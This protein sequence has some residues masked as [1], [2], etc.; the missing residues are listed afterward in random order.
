MPPLTLP[1]TVR[2]SSGDTHLMIRAPGPI[3]FGAIGPEV[4][5]AADLP[6]ETHLHH[7]LGR[8][9]PSAVLGRPPLLSGLTLT[10]TAQTSLLVDG[11]VVLGCVAGP[12]AGRSVALDGEPVEVGRDADADLQLNDPELSRRHLR[13]DC[14]ENG[15]QVTDLGSA[16]G[17]QVDGVAASGDPTRPGGDESTT[18]QDVPDG[19]VIRAGSS[20]LR[21]L[22][23]GER[24]LSR[25][26]DGRGHLRVARP[27]RVLAPFHVDV[28]ADPGPAPERPR[29]PLPLLAAGIGAVVGGVIAWVTGMWMFLLFAALGPVYL[30]AGAL[31]DRV[32][33]RRSHRQAV[34]EHRRSVQERERAVAAAVLADRRDAW[35]RHS[36][37]V[38]LARRCRSGS[39]RL[40]ERRPTEPEFAQLVLAV[41]RRPARLPLTDPPVADDMPLPV[42]LADIGVLGLT[43]HAR[44]T[45]RS[46]LG[47][48]VALHSPVDLGLVVFSAAPDLLPLRDLPHAAD[49]PLGAR[50]LV[51]GPAEVGPAL[52]M[53]HSALAGADRPALTVLVLDGAGAWRD[54]PGMAQLLAAAGDPRLSGLAVLC[55]EEERELLPAECQAVAD[56]STTGVAVRG[57]QVCDGGP[58]GV[59]AAYLAG[60][61]ADLAPLR[62]IDAALGALP[63]RCILGDWVRLGRE[64]DDLRRRWADPS[65][66]TV[67]GVGRAGPVEIDLDRDGPHL[68]VAGTTGAGKSELLQTLVVGLAAAAPPSVTS[69]LLVDY[70][71]GAAFA[72]LLGLPHAAGLITDLDADLAARALTSLRAEI[73]SRESALARAGHP[74]LARWRAADPGA[75]GRLVIVVDEFATLAADLPDFLAGLL[76]ISRR[77]R[78]LGLHLVLAT[79]RPAG[80]VT[81]ALRA[82]IG[83]RI[84][85]RVT[86]DAESRDVLDAPDAARLPR[87]RPGRAVLRT[88]TGRTV[89]QAA[90][91]TVPPDR[92]VE[93]RRRDDDRTVLRA[94]SAAR[95][96]AV[97]QGV[98]T[99]DTGGVVPE[100][101]PP[102][103]WTPDQPV[104]GVAAHDAS[105]ARWTPTGPTRSVADRMTGPGTPADGL[106][107][108]TAAA[109]RETRAPDTDLAVLLAAA[110]R[111]APAPAPRPWLPHLPRVLTPV[112]LATLGSADSRAPDSP[113]APEAIG[114]LDRP[115]EQRQLPYALP[116]TSTLVVGPPG[117]GRS[118]ALRACARAA[119]AV[120]GS[121]VVLDTTGALADL[122][123]WPA[124]TTMLDDREPALL[125][126]AVDRLRA[127]LVARAA[128]PQRAAVPLVV[129]VDGWES[130]VSTLDTVDY[131][132]AGGVL[133][134]IA[135]RGPALGV[136]VIAAGS[137]R[138]AV[139]RYAPSF[140]TVLAL[141]D[142][143]RFG[144]P[145]PDA[146]PGRARVG[147][148]HLQIVSA[149]AGPPPG[150]AAPGPNPV[151]VRRLP[152]VV[153]YAILPAAVGRTAWLG[154]GGDAAAPVGLDLSGPGGGFLIAG[155]RRS[156][157]SSALDVLARSALGL[158]V[159]VVAL[160][161]RPGREQ[162]GTRRVEVGMDGRELQDLLARH[163]GPLL[164]V[165]DQVDEWAEHPAAALLARFLT[166]AGQGQYLAAGCRMDRAHRGGRGLIGE[167]A[168]F[169]HG[170][171][172][173][174][175]AADGAL[176]D[177]A[178]PRRRSA[179]GPGRGHLV[180]AGRVI[181]V[182]IADPAIDR[183]ETPT[184][185]LPRTR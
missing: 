95:P 103:R 98:P 93:I 79:Q 165:A 168:A 171:L 55:L 126:R 97:E 7:G 156:G 92:S 175:D 4:L 17:V 62:D 99:G 129:L 36:D 134:E 147:A 112:D 145:R 66:R 158:D 12:D 27:P 85:L 141:G 179:A 152:A 101:D 51:R 87:D 43:G 33:G 88:G 56:V 161:L 14:G 113:G 8:L 20:R 132:A 21:I 130:V 160:A 91:V 163:E 155:P 153:P 63:A 159:P 118:T 77:G 143:D 106:P 16:N 73:R 138:A 102:A 52:V 119:A 174:A 151:V 96:V 121:L 32:G 104:G 40:W 24:P 110:R 166:V 83:A 162:P 89:F 154:V 64:V 70:K 135:A 120:P 170:V 116:T 58:V 90:L 82:N 59:G 18:R 71:G 26:P 25:T 31:G 50:A 84:C 68:L 184:P 53:L 65:V 49:G 46:L 94:R 140:P 29:R 109:R 136:R 69:F 133:G 157:T 60:L 10:T 13:L 169:R 15:W 19:A 183:P 45:L 117:S 148:H 37:P 108:A 105:R 22:V 111:L 137:P 57:G 142:P 139:S 72:G 146:P 177:A 42:A 167:I 107:G 2:S 41:G 61:V 54:H 35:D 81:P 131:G 28:P 100:N 185:V 1:L 34:A 30:L 39:A 5:R 125:L 180:G 76:D 74:D 11:P 127:E 9:P 38:V 182:Q 124:T 6:A 122:A 115:E 144:Q 128:S 75:P 67:I 114:L 149:P 164:L 78:S 47:Q 23:S 150:A 178:V 181:S 172:L 176:L 80:V 173:Q 123:R 86:D 44:A 3:S 48:L